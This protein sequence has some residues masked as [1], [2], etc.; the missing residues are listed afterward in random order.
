MRAV[1]DGTTLNGRGAKTD[2]GVFSSAI[3]WPEDSGRIELVGWKSNTT[4]GLKGLP[5]CG[6]GLSF[7][8]R[9]LRCSVDDLSKNSSEDDDE[10][11]GQ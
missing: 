4:A 5:G 9:N 10:I 1:F 8:R 11:Q 3:W 6:K 7:G 2:V